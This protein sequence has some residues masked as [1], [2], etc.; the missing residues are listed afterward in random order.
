[1]AQAGMVHA[2]PHL[3]DVLALEAQDEWRFGMCVAKL[4]SLYVLA[5]RKKGQENRVCQA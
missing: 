4:D 3:A 5:G 1:M 2:T